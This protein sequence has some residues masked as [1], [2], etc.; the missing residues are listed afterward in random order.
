MSRRTEEWKVNA[1]LTTAGRYKVS[2]KA[3]DPISWASFCTHILV[4]EPVGELLLDV[5]SVLMTNRQHP[6][7]FSVTAGSNVTVSLLV[8][9]TLLYS[10]S[11]YATGEEA[12]A[13]LNFDH[14][15][16]VVVEL[17]AENRVSS[18]NKRVRVS[19]EGNRK[20]SP[21]IRINP[22][23][24]APASRSPVHDLADNV[25]IYAATQAYPT[26]TDITLLAVAGLADPVDFLWHFG[27]STSQRTTSRSVTKRYHTPGR[28]AVV[29]V[30]SRGRTS[31]TSDVFPLVVQRTGEFRVEVT[32]SNLVSSA[33]LSGHIFVVDR[34]CQPP[35]VKN[36]GPRK[37]QVR[38]HELV[39]LGVTYETEVDCDIPGGLHYTWALFDSAGRVFP[40]PLVDTHRQNL[41]LPSHLLHYDTYTAIARVQ[42][43][44]SVVYSNYS[45]RV[46]VIP[47]PPVAFIQGSTNIFINT[48]N[49]TVVTLDGQRSYDPDFPMNPVRCRTSVNFLKQNFDQFRF[50]LNIHS[51]N[52]SASSEVFLTLTPNV[53]GK[54]S[55]HCPQCQ[56]EQVNWH[57]SFSVSAACEGCDISPKYIQYTW[58]LYRVNASSKPVIEDLTEREPSPVFSLVDPGTEGS[59]EEP[60]HPPLGEFDPPK[61]LYSS[62]EYPP[63]ALDNSGVRYSDHFLQGEFPID[64]DSSAD[65]EFSFPVLETGD[66]GGQQGLCSESG[67]RN[68]SALVRLGNRVEIRNYVSL[69]S[70]ILNRLSLDTKAGTRAQERTRNVLIRTVCEL[71]SSGQ[72]LTTLVALL[73][74]S[75]QAALTRNDFTPE[76][77]PSADIKQAL[78]S[79]P[80]DEI[81]DSP[82]GI[83]MDQGLP[84]STKQALQLVADILQTAS[85]LMLKYILSHEA[86]EHR[87]GS[88]LIALYVAYLNQ[89]STELTSGSTIYYMSDSL[90]RLLVAHRSRETRSRPRRLCA[91]GVLSELSHSPYTWAR[92][93]ETKSSEPGYVLLRSQINYHT[94]NI[95][96][97][98]LRRAIQL[99]VVFARP[100]NKVFPILLL[101]R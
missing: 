50:L 79:D 66:L 91:L 88:G 58:S 75:L 71:E 76:M 4:Q 9:A 5:P 85:D 94:F 78:E 57:Q 34:P 83:Y 27:D 7:S 6:V 53:I 47:S 62:S 67:L 48:R 30:M 68:L 86:H 99:S 11:S 32:V 38:R 70:S 18:Q 29:V 16:T 2:V 82:S 39:H 22:T 90:I 56:A 95:T 63:L 46:Q 43:A 96:Q 64:S 1:S 10:N 42:V 87:V 52:R 3:F 59:G 44:S 84:I 19:V 12:M 74:R 60:F 31:L 23:G 92:H 45:V 8:N 89:T 25:W 93:P 101:F 72:T 98:H 69:L 80:H 61:P 55:V 17:R 28:Y 21:Q 37:L 33:S 73:S 26:N 97:E 14:T 100:L 65:W 13:V 51:G 49:T 41:M 77:S 20:S 15:G 40:L 24:R 36:M 54:V 81:Q 35:P